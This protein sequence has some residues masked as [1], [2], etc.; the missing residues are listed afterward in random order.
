MEGHIRDLVGHPINKCYF[1]ELDICRLYHI[2]LSPKSIKDVNPNPQP[3]RLLFGSIIVA[4]N[5]LNW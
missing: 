2:L 5:L 3:S 4:L 1:V